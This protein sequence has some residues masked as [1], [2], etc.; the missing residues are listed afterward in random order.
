M[1]WVR[2]AGPAGSRRET[3]HV[4]R[5]LRRRCRSRGGVYRPESTHHSPACS[6][7]SRNPESLSRVP[8]HRLDIPDVVVGCTEHHAHLEEFTD[9]D[10]RWRRRP[11]R[12]RNG[13]AIAAVVTG[14]LCCSSATSSSVPCG[15]KRDSPAM[16]EHSGRPLSRGAHCE[17]HRGRSAP[18]RTRHDNGV[19]R[20]TFSAGKRTVLRSSAGWSIAYHVT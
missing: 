2:E 1:G 4:A 20:K 16:S 8:L 5:S 7:V 17:S 14:Q 11:V 12:M 15:A 13:N 6:A 10:A 9:R 19:T 3:R 18:A